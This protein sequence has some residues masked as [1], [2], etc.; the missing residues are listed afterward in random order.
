MENNKHNDLIMNDDGKL[1]FN[2]YNPNNIEITEKDI[3]NILFPHIGFVYKIYNIELFKR[4]FIHRSYC[5]LKKDENNNIIIAP[6]PKN[7]LTLKSKSNERLEFL[8]DGVLENVTKYYIYNRFPSSDEGFMTEKK[9]SIVKNENIGRLAYELGLHKYYIISRHADEKKIRQNYKKLG[10]LFEAFLGALFLDANKV[11]IDNVFNKHI[12]GPG[13]QVAQLFLNSVFEKYI[14]WN[15]LI[16]I[17]D[18]YKNN[19]QVILQKEFKNTPSY[20]ILNYNDSNKNE[21]NTINNDET[22][23]VIDENET[24]VFLINQNLIL[25]HYEMGVFLIIGYS[26]VTYNELNNSYIYGKDFNNFDEIH[27]FLNNNDNK[28]ILFFSK[29]SNKIKKK[30]EQIACENAL[31]LLNIN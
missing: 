7:C 12:L 3:Q 11:N 22:T 28:I 1:Y 18:N 25:N 4:A 29:G 15:N 31:H 30:A 6:K 9:I 27:N 21:D 2:P 16:E 19:F 26:F 13:F 14:N 23:T 5:K 10:C 20:I 17:N 8:G 24:N